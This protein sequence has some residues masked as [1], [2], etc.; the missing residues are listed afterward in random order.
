MPK[1]AN[2][3]KPMFGIPARW[4]HFTSKL[5]LKYTVSYILM[6]LIPLSL[7]TALVYESA[8]RSLRTEIEQANVN[9]LNQVKTTIDER[10][11]ELQ[12]IASK[13]SYDE[14]LTPYMVRHPLYSADAIRTLASYKAN[15]SI[16]ED[17]FLYFHHDS[18]IYSST[19]LTYVNVVFERMYKFE[20][21]TSEQLVRDLNELKHPV[22]RPA[23][24]VSVYSR[25]DP[26]LTFLVP[27]KP[28][29]Q[30]PYGTVVYLMKESKLTGVMDS[31]L[32]DFSG[33]SYIFDQK[34][35]A[36][37]VNNHGASPQAEDLKVLPTLEPGIH[38][39]SFDGEQ[40]SVVV[41]KSEANGWLYVTTMPSY[42]F[43]SRVAHIKELVFLIFCIAVLTGIIAAMLLAK[44]QY[45]PI[46]DLLEFAKIKNKPADNLKSR[47]EWD[48]IKQTIHDYSARI[49]MQQPYVRNQCL[50]LLLKY[51]KPDDPEIERMIDDAGLMLPQGQGFYFS[52][53]LAWDETAEAEKN[54][55]EQQHLQEM[56]SE[57][58]FSELG[59]HVYGMEFSA[60]EQFALIVSLSANSRKEAQSR[61]LSII[62][63]IKVLVIENSRLVPYFGVGTLYDDPANLNQSFIEASAALEYRMIGSNG[64]VTYFGQIAELSVPSAETFWISRKTILKLEHGLKQG[65]E[66][67]ARQMIAAIINE[68]KDESLSVSLLRCICF[69]LLN[70]LLRTAS[71]LGMNEVFLN[72]ASFT[73]FESLEELEA[74]LCSLASRICLQVERNAENGQHSLMD[75]IVAYVNQ[76]FADYTLSLEH[77]ALRYSISTSYL[78]RCFK[79]K[80]GY[81]F[82]QYIWQCRMK[83]V[84][85]LLVNTDAPLKEII[86]Q[87]GY[88]DA[89]NFIRKFKKET[90]YTPGQYRKLHAAKPQAVKLEAVKPQTVKP[91]MPEPS[92]P[93][94]L[95]GP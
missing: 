84:I 48:W 15:S 14:H 3:S 23:E 80:T 10:M 27:I 72:I 7:V 76:Q 89:P 24:K 33:S 66:L 13:I 61:I 57:F 35:N 25:S 50:L 95:E 5:L 55:K 78:S 88:L 64:R 63:A 32:S 12:E 26:M 82:S 38:S 73:S 29:D 91:P 65:N 18:I 39:L 74:K 71:E 31:I 40:Y 86:E 4:N 21:W 17:L 70:S 93:E 41:V 69:D 90:G 77:V 75:D 30:Y 43:F 51:G 37:T 6:F 92:A 52:V 1:T 36:L 60:A 44:R 68:L 47:N 67:V 94:A 59:T 54:W 56:L 83:E 62:E 85:R 79:E 19:G 58:E 16:L 34:G 45:H 42:Q 81:N 87:V 20:N 49:D 11:A 2:H 53:I 28:N 46:K 8:V 9:Q 22:M